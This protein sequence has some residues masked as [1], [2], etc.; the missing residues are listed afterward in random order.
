[1]TPLVGGAFGAVAGLGLF[2]IIAALGGELSTGSGT[3]R[4]RSLVGSERLALTLA[5]YLA[6]FL[7]TWALTGWVVGGL[8][9]VIIA[10]VVPRIALTRQA[11]A[12]EVAKIE[13]IAS[14]CEMLRDTISA[15][16]GLHEAI[17]VSA[18]VA[19]N[20]IEIPVRRLSARLHH[21]NLEP[22]LRAFA[23]DVDHP[24]G[25]LVV[26]SLLLAASGQGGSLS[27]QLTELAGTARANAT[28]RLRVE[29]GRARIYTSATT[30]GGVFS[31]FALGLIVLQR[32]FLAAF[33]DAAGQ[34]MLL[35][36]AAL[37]L[38]GWASMYRLGD[39]TELPGVLHEDREAKR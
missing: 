33:D 10:R 23:D 2:V 24:I 34:L 19:P 29:A 16:S 1:M 14:W 30:V 27:G 39:F 8:I 36:I 5:L 3:G 32:D 31:I 17:R 37:M 11:R 25:D 9:T 4:L 12:T 7:A 13:A 18:T 20:P 6:A 28:M 22:S 38:F 15:S 26:A 21:G 35:V